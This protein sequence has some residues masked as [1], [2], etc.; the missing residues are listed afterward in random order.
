M[1]ICVIIVLKSAFMKWWVF[2]H[3]VPEIDYFVRSE[4]IHDAKT[5][6][7]EIHIKIIFKRSM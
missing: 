6:L 3:R 1:E 7:A 2:Y 4:L 5:N